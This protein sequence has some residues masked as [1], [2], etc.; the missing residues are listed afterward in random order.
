MACPELLHSQQRLVHAAL[1]SASCRRAAGERRGRW[2]GRRIS[3]SGGS[4][5]AKR[6]GTG[7]RAVAGQQMGGGL[8][9]G[10]GGAAS[11][12]RGWGGA[13]AGL[14]VGGGAGAGLR[15]GPG[16]Q[17]GAGAGAGLRAVVG[18]QMGGGPRAGG[19][20]C[21]W[22]EAGNAVLDAEVRRGELA[23]RSSPRCPPARQLSPDSFPQ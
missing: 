7:R 4:G 12:R 18:P 19:R 16:P 8:G 23:G 5:R 3:G 15:A 9:Q 6:L 1:S 2:G 10:W 11:G 14:Q 21:F 17:M 22:P 20:R 13:G